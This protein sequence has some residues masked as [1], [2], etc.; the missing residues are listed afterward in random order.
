ML[1]ATVNS[2]SNLKLYTKHRYTRKQT[3]DNS[4]GPENHKYQERMLTWEHNRLFEW[5]FPVATGG[6]E[7][8]EGTYYSFSLSEFQKFLKG[9]PH[10]F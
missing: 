6:T 7:W 2:D 4:R 8:R 10:F 1:C 3:Q 5:R 9:L